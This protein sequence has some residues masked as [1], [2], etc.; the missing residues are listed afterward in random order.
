[1]STWSPL[2]VIL[3]GII[4][5]H[6][7][8][9]LLICLPFSSVSSEGSDFVSRPKCIQALGTRPGLWQALHKDVLEKAAAPG[10]A[11]R[12]RVGGEGREGEAVGRCR[13]CRSYSTLEAQQ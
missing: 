13:I 4:T 3:G 11:G 9:F 1:M 12:E 2:S 5:L 8:F 7:N 10:E 6:R